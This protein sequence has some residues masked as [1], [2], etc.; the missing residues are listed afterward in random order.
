MKVTYDRQADASYILASEIAAGGVKRTYFCDP[1]AV[2]GIIKLDFD[3][4]MAAGAHA[5]PN[6]LDPAD[7]LKSWRSDEL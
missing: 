2:N 3:A 7:L 5:K 6:S 4:W 1:N